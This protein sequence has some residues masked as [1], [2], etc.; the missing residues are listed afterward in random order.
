[1]SLIRPDL[2]SIAA[3]PHGSASQA[4]L[5]AYGIAP[6]AA[7]DFSVNTNPLGPAPSV[8][9]AIAGADWTRYPGD[10]EPTLRAAI[11]NH[12]GVSPDQVVLGNGS[13]ELIWLI[14][15]AC[16]R[17]GD[18]VAIAETT[19]GEYA[20]AARLAAARVVDM[21]QSNQAR[22]T[23]VC[24]PNN[25]DGAYQPRPAMEQ[26][27]QRTSGVLAI[28]E[29]YVGFLD[30]RWDSAALLELGNVVVLRSMTK[31]HALPGLR[32]GYGFAPR[33]IAQ[34]LESVRPP[35]SVNAGALR[36]GLAALE[37]A[38]QA[39]VAAARDVV[40]AARRLLT[41]GFER[42]GFNV[43]QSEAN[44]V[45]VEVGDATGFR[46]ALLRYGVVVR[47]CTSFGLPGHVRVACKRP[48]E[49]QRLLAALADAIR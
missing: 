42:R 44:F 33:E 2:A 22:L 32:L 21:Q 9:R 1:M 35:W 34:A 24:N 3:V 15:L 25:P 5:A 31:D 48:A 14:A 17:P 11:A 40:Q 23:F 6:E 20:R 4:E 41:Q 43:R 47:D 27:A 49:C 8:L 10:D 38:A 16:V 12:V 7:L 19:F 18:C 36:A 30:Q 26:L 39:H 29:A 46:R 28:D 37:P 45:L 13:V